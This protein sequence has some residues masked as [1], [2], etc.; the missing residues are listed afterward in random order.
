MELTSKF[1]ANAGKHTRCISRVFGQ[2]TTWSRFS[3]WAVDESISLLA[4][5]CF[6]R[7]H[8]SAW[9]L[10]FSQQWRF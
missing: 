2:L 4:R 1:I 9:H 6:P 3:P 10:K 8:V 7:R 5:L